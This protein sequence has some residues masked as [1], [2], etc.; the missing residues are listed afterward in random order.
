[1]QRPVTQIERLELYHRA[2][3]KDSCRNDCVLHKSGRATPI[4]RC[5]LLRV[6]RT[7][8]AAPEGPPMTHSRPISSCD[9]P[10]LASSTS[11]TPSFWLAKAVELTKTDGLGVISGSCIGPF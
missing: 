3:A 6:E 2:L 9:F 1:M 5:P 11:L 8:S 4:L 10:A 7:K